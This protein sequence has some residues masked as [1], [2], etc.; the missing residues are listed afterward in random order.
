MAAGR[1]RLRVP[2]WEA[3]RFSRERLPL[4]KKPLSLMYIHT[5]N[6]GVKNKALNISQ[7]LPAPRAAAIPR[8]AQRALAASKFRGELWKW[9]AAS[10]GQAAAARLGAGHACKCLWVFFFLGVILQERRI[11]STAAALREGSPVKTVLAQG[12]CPLP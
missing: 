8:G 9:E 1:Q 4:K 7:L 6:G 12:F 11:F 2:D 10:P 5:G 3:Q